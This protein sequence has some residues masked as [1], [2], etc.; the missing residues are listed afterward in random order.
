M[1]AFLQRSRHGTVFYFRRRV[2][3]DLRPYIGQPYIAKSLGTEIRSQAIIAARKFAAITDYLFLELRTMPGKVDAK[4]FLKDFTEDPNLRLR[5]KLAGM[6]VALEEQQLELNRQ[7]AEITG[8]V[9]QHKREL[10]VASTIVASASHT[11]AL[12]SATA[13]SFANGV[14]DYLTGNSQLKA[15]TRGTYK[16][17]L[18]HAQKYFGTTTNLHTIGQAE[19]SKYAQAVASEIP[20]P[21]TAANY[22]Q[23]VAGFL[24]WFR[25]REGWGASITTKTLLPKKTRPDTED[26]DAFTVEQLAVLFKNAGTYRTREPYKYWATILPA[27]TGC[28]IEE[29]AQLNL[30]TDLRHDAVAGI[31]YFDLN[32]NP[33]SDGVTRKS[34][35]NKASWRTVPIHKALIDN[36][37]IE[38]LAP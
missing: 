36:G 37:L 24:N 13:I 31:W 18:Q 12:V 16:G 5:L 28:R 38:Y 20:D 14:A 22:I 2:P 23:T 26:R 32:A 7:E 25:I 17:K 10:Q 8:L 6:Q 9:N 21:T 35:K 34:L 4:Q 33:D 29:L 30:E 1:A 3:D 27:F 15:N 19:F 11:H